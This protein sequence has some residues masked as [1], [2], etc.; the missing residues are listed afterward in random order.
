M[1]NLDLDINNY[2]E[3]EL[4]SLIKYE[5]DNKNASPIQI[6]NQV[7]KVIGQCVQK[8]KNI[9][10]LESFIPFL[11]EVNDKLIEYSEIR[12]PVQYYPTN[13]NILQ[14]QNQTSGGTHSITTDK[15]IPVL[16]VNDYQLPAGVINP[17]ERRTVKKII[18]IDSIFRE[19]YNNTS[20]SDF[21]WFLPNREYKVVSIKLVSLELP[22]MWYSISE[23]NNSNTFSITTYNIKGLPDKKHKIEMPSGN[24]MA[25]EFAIALTNYMLNKGEGLQFLICTINSITS[26]TVIRCRENLDGCENIFDV[27]KD[28]YSPEFYFSIDFGENNALECDIGS[29]SQSN[30]SLKENNED[31]YSQYCLGSFLGFTKRYYEVHKEDTYTD[32]VYNGNNIITY[33]CFLQSESSYGNG[34]TNYIFVSVDDYNNNFIN[35]TIIASSLNNYLGTNILGRISVN[36][37]FNAILMNTISDKIFKQ[38][39]YMGPINLNKFHIKLLDKYGQVIDLN[40]ND[41]SLAIEL[42]ILYN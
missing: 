34:R 28:H 35:E 11:N 14:S 29:S 18:S 25:S 42:T 7:N 37:T 12:N 20:S 1:D 39:D 4:Y 27:S 16:N 2:S 36:E 9:D 5:G 15:I 41:V 13:Y 21:V 6:T 32:Y 17:I 3:D 23:K 24:Y 40:N 19:N 22:V 10:F 30:D 33:E 26:K 38:R 8:Y 31:R